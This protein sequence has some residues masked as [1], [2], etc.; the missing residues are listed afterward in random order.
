MIEVTV[1][2]NNRQL[3]DPSSVMDLVSA[4][5]ITG[6]RIAIEV[7]GEIVP[8]SQHADHLLGAGDKVEIVGAIGGG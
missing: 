4:M 5:S 2:G 6:K 1:N 3:N 7:N 8:A